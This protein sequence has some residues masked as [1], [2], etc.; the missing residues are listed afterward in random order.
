[1]PVVVLSITAGL[2]TPVTLLPEVAGNNGATVPLQIEVENEKLG[3]I[4][5]LTV[6]F[7]VATES[8]PAA[9]TRVAVYVPAEG[10]ELPFQL[11]GKSAA[12]VVIEVVLTEG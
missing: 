9:F 12:H 3:I 10:Y 8:Q 1:M 7:N 6:K 2:H 5:V 4:I 11:K